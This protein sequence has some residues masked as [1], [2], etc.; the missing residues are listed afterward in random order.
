[1]RFLETLVDS[2]R[3]KDLFPIVIS[4]YDHHAGTFLFAVNNDASEGVQFDF[5]HDEKGRGVLGLR[6]SRLLD[7]DLENVSGYPIVPPVFEC[8]Y[9]AAKARRKG[10]V[11]S[12]QLYR[13][14]AAEFDR[15]QL[16]EV[17]RG[18]THSEEIGSWLMGRESLRM[19]R[20][21]RHR[22]QQCPRV[23]HRIRYP[24]GFWWHAPMSRESVVSE[25]AA[26]FG[27]VLLESRHLEVTSRTQLKAGI[28]VAAIRRRAALVATT[29]E[30][31]PHLARA[32]LGVQ[33][34]AGVEDVA[35]SVVEQMAVRFVERTRAPQFPPPGLGSV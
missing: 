18:L 21:L 30:R 10:N 23:V 22:L 2:L 31:V 13:E 15:V 35:V 24:V 32:D 26:R 8:I 14:Q 27:R 34:D 19:G 12:L 1:M 4:R 17:S 11:S 33:A 6:S 16:L 28:T 9:N 5:L 7:A 3:A 29:G 25:V 20:T